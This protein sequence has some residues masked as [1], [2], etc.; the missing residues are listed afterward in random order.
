MKS[1]FHFLLS[2][3]DSFACNEAKARL[4]ADSE[5]EFDL[6]W[7]ECYLYEMVGNY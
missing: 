4:G 7:H 5:I 2:H 3:F 1:S 6:F